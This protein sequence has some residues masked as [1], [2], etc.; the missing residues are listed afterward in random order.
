[1]T[2]VSTVVLRLSHRYQLQWIVCSLLCCFTEPFS[3]I[4]N[5]NVPRLGLERSE[6]AEQAVEVIT[7]LLERYG[8]GGPCSDTVADFTYHNSFLIA[9]S[10]EAWVLET[11]GKVWAAEKIT[12][13]FLFSF[14]FDGIE[15]GTQWRSWLTHCATSQ[16]VAGSIPNGVTGIFH[17]PNPSGRTMAPGVDSASNRNGYQ[18]YF[19]GVK[20]ATA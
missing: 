13:L 3:C 11:A 4:F 17:W 20:A 2:C 15:W 12:G 6:T 18:E 7:D 5:V 9:D 19:L 8:Q 10:K 14:P 16:K 1:M